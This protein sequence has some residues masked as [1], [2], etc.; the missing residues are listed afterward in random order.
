ML[1]IRCEAHPGQRSHLMRW[2]GDECLPRIA[3][4]RGFAS[5]CALA[6]AVEPPMTS[7]QAIRGRDATVDSVVLVSGYTSD[8]LDTLQRDD[9]AAQALQAQGAMPAVAYGR[10]RFACRA[11]A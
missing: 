9:L 11:D 7:E 4:R 6:A 3:A 8:L 2:L 5:A 10:Y 1:T